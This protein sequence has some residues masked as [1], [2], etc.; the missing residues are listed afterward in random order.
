MLKCGASR[1]VCFSCCHRRWLSSRIAYQSTISHVFIL[2]CSENVVDI[3]NEVQAILRHS[4]TVSRTLISVVLILVS[5]VGHRRNGRIVSDKILFHMYW[6]VFECLYIPTYTICRHI[7]RN[8]RHIFIHY[9][10]HNSH[11]QLK[12]IRRWWWRRIHNY[13]NCILIVTLAVDR[14]VGVNESDYRRQISV[15]RIKCFL[16]R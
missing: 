14:G 3:W 7:Q 12:Y 9:E 1:F 4:E 15:T 11:A 2:I 6:S 13:N 16:L 8:L 10:T 5:V